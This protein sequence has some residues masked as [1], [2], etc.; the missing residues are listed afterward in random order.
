MQFVLVSLLETHPDASF[1]FPSDLRNSCF[2]FKIA[3]L[4]CDLNALQ[5]KECV[6]HYCATLCASRTKKGK[7]T[8][9]GYFRNLN[10]SDL[11]QK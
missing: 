9:H 8:K 1:M 3:Q 6:H 4:H 2:F 11:A 7:K 10:H 5:W